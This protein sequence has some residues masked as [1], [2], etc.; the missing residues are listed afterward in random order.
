MVAVGDHVMLTRT[1]PGQTG[2]A[3]IALGATSPAD[4]IH[5]SA[6]GTIADRDRKLRNR[7]ADSHTMLEKTLWTYVP[8]SI[9]SA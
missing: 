6:G 4:F 3:R 1:L 8:R 7:R 9:Q 5:V 2:E